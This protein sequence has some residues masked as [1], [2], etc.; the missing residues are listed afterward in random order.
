MSRIA[1]TLVVAASMAL[2]AANAH[3][4]EFIYEAGLNGANESPPVVTPGSGHT[5]VT[6]DDVL[7]TLRIEVTF[8]DLIGNTT[9]S[10]IHIRPDL[11][12]PNGGV[13]TQV[14]SFGGFPLGVTSGI[15]DN[16]FDL[17]QASSW[18][19]AFLTANGGT[20]AGA[21]ASFFAGLQQGRAYLN[22]HTSFSPPGEIRGNLAVVPEL[23][24]WTMLLLGF[25]LVGA[26]LR[27]RPWQTRATA[28]A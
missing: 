15:Y 19:P 9:A 3:A 11:A 21:E 6:Y 7:H 28:A 24:T 17:T 12:T 4:A 1:L 10:H 16:T 27:R 2:P 8:A 23:A 22:V 25:G 13:A 14:P 26:T 5:R 20:P 18:N